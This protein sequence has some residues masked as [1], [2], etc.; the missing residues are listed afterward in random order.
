MRLK[1]KKISWM[2]IKGV[3]S[4]L[5]Y[6]LFW[7]N[8]EKKCMIKI[9][10]PCVFLSKNF[11][12]RIPKSY[13]QLI[14]SSLKC[15]NCT[16]KIKHVVECESVIPRPSPKKW[17]GRQ[18]PMTFFLQNWLSDIES[19]LKQDALKDFSCTAPLS[20]LVTVH[21]LFGA[22]CLLHH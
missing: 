19:Q 18:C 16:C 9:Y 5:Q 3:I 20:K 15:R 6:S 14:T 7:A 1:I 8:H 22:S 11:S 17:R 2:S 10:F 12:A 21:H 4:A 13:V